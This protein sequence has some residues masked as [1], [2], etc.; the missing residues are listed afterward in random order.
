MEIALS[1][2]HAR[3]T[4]ITRG[5][6]TFRSRAGNTLEISIELELGSREVTRS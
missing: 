1:P 5:C 6:P 3:A 2:A 4:A